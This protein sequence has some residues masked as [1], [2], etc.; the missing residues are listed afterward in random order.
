MNTQ[1]FS[2][3]F[4]PTLTSEGDVPRNF[5]GIAYSGGVIPSYGRY[6]DVAI[7]L[8]SMKTPTKPVFALLNHDTNQRAGRCEVFNRNNAIELSGSF[9][10]ATTAGQ[11]VAAE[12]AEGAPWEFSVGI[13]AE[14]EPFNKP[15][16]IEVNGQSLKVNGVFRNAAVREVSFV[17]A[18][19][20]PHTKAVSFEKQSD[21][22]TTLEST[23]E[24]NDLQEKVESL[25][26][27]NADLQLQMKALH[28]EQYQVVNDLTEQLSAKD[29]SLKTAI[30]A[31]EKV[32]NELQQ[33]KSEVR[34]SAVKSL[35]A[36]LNRDVSDDTIQSY[37][38]M[39]EN[40]FAVVSTD[41][42][43]LKPVNLNAD[44]FKEVATKG[45][46]NA[47]EIDLAAQLFNQVAGVK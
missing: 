38:N 21:L 45:K 31:F 2:L 29:E 18:G 5:S 12:C 32:S 20:D 33:F 39:D 47:T 22:L 35:F 8:S 34:M 28:D 7:D 1:N 26:A 42:R 6:G 23:M 40:T 41:L 27:L 3:S 9:S 10:K 17:P 13:H 36:E 46:E 14:F 30:E 15:T 24:S 44:L 19:A 37:L 25:T 43:S 11:L 4:S 16:V